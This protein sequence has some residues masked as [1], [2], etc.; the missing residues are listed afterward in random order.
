MNALV[1]MDRWRGQWRCRP[2]LARPFSCRPALFLAAAAGAVWMVPEVGRR[3]AALLREPSRAE[4]AK[5][6]RRAACPGVA[7]GPRGRG[8]RQTG[9]MG[10]DAVRGVPPP[11]L[12]AVSGQGSG[13]IPRPSP[14][15]LKQRLVLADRQQLL[16][17]FG[18]GRRADADVAGV[19]PS[20]RHAIG[21]WNDRA[22]APRP[23]T[24][25]RRSTVGDHRWT[26]RQAGE[27]PGRR[28]VARGARRRSAS[29]GAWGGLPDWGSS[30]RATS[31][32]RPLEAG[33][34][35]H[36]LRKR[37]YRRWRRFFALAQ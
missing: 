29:A 28:S 17:R 1:T 37:G 35:G 7:I 36:F 24:P 5:L 26:V 11:N 14:L 27:T 20:G 2:F 13:G 18:R 12:T 22:S 30:R 32:R 23:G 31:A 21:W 8:S 9:W 34:I 10:P 19:T 4:G 16:Q 6:F 33:F 25:A 3:S 15:R